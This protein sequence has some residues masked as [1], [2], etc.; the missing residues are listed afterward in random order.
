MLIP[1]MISFILLTAIALVLPFIL[2]L[3]VFEP[4]EE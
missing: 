3:N 4:V 2:K 1:V